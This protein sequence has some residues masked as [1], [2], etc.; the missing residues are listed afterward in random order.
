M[1]KGRNRMILLVIGGIIALFLNGCLKQQP[2][3][4]EGH[5]VSQIKS[6]PVWLRD[7][8]P[9]RS[10]HF[11]SMAIADFNNDGQLD[12]VGGSYEPGAIFLWF[13]DGFGNWE[14]IQRFRIRSDIRFISA[15]DINN[16]G[17]L[18]I[19]SSGR[20]DTKGI[21]VWINN[22]V[23]TN[24][25]GFFKAAKS[26]I[27]KELYEGLRLADIN[28]DGN[29]DIIAANSTDVNIGGIQVWLGDG[30]GNFIIETGPTRKGIY[31]D[32]AVGDINNDGKLDIVGAGWGEVDGGVRVWLGSGDGR[33][34][35]MKEIEKGSFW[36]VTLA[37]INSDGNLDIIAASNFNGVTVFYGDGKGYFANKEKLAESGSFWRVKAVDLNTDGFLDIIGTS[38][39]GKGIVVWYQ[40]RTGNEIRWVAKD[41][42]LPTD[43]FYFDSAFADF[44][45][46][47]RP[48]IAA[49]TH[50]EGIKVWFRSP[51]EP[52][53]VKKEVVKEKEIVE[54]IV[55][56]EKIIEKKVLMVPV[57]YTAVFFDTGKA[58]I[59]PESIVI[60]NSVSEFLK[61][62]DG[63]IVKLEGYADPRRI[64]TS[65]FPDNKMLSIGRAG[66]VTEYLINAGIPKGRIE[67][68]GF[69]D[70][71]IK[72]KGDD[73]ESMQKNRRVDITIIYKGGNPPEKEKTNN[74]ADEKKKII[75]TTNKQLSD[76][77][78]MEELPYRDPFGE[79]GDIVPVVDYKAF[80]L[81][82]NV[83]EYR[84]GPNDILDVV[85]W[86]GIKENHF[87]VMVSP[88]GTLSFSYIKDFMVS[89]FTQTEL[90][91]EFIKSLEKFVKNPAVKVYVSHKEAHNASIFGAVRD[92]ARQ[93]T[94]PGTY[95]MYGKERLSQ[96]LSRAGG[97]LPN[98]DLTRVQFTRQGKT[99]FVNLFDAIFKADL[100]QDVIIDSGDVI[101][102]PS[103]A[104][105]KNK[106]F[107]FGEVMRPGLF[108]YDVSMSL[109]EAIVRAGGPSFYGKADDVFI[110]RGDE[111]KPE[112]VRVNMKDI[113]VKGD[114]RN[115][116]ALQ[117]NDILYVANNVYGDIRD[118]VRAISPF[119][120]ITRLPMD[121][122]SSTALPN[123]EG[124]PIRRDAAP[125]PTT[126]IT[127]PPASPPEGTVWESK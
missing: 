118:F 49:S 127:A 64:M 74:P 42:G 111:T 104:E 123:W 82:G 72:Y 80:K 117:N 5:G 39:D 116:I 110:I 19:I 33:W 70:N 115:N 44:N 50:G 76:E 54:K 2:L 94:G 88:Q 78:I 126:L 56:K 106:I 92:L 25:D 22:K 12:I 41:E 68:A 121:V 57:F 63:T 40:Q 86:E 122:Y 91:I 61:R 58:D 9:E 100:R 23:L 107:I 119:L 108:Q 95:K 38:N 62:V 105:I 47:G 24:E 89:G 11:R 101:F 112:A 35:A 26:V 17:F 114:F 15:G 28:N 75:E 6:D 16:D 36:G 48:D 52:I 93:P 73:H 60:L 53:R 67:E 96:F 97:H 34:S 87:K 55:E 84:I 14:R 45:H 7:F 21:Q 32:V 59:R 120:S 30:K 43:G 4:M 90:E 113:Y 29:L 8:G 18:D 98:A 81:I 102:I 99:Y 31:Y 71:V 109:L 20:G 10:G 1:A 65:E 124:F 13:G 37:D 125:T 66:K 46:D 79:T 83:P 3:S 77:K 51:G 85:I 69:G 103:K 27:E